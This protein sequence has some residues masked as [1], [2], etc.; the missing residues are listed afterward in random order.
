MQVQLELP[1][2]V[3]VDPGYVRAAV[4]AVLYATGKLS[5]HQACQI[6]NVTR[7]AFDEMLPVYGFSVLVDSDDN[8]DIELGAS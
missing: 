4:M 5:A 1:D 6:L 3:N 2:S 7:R 8:L